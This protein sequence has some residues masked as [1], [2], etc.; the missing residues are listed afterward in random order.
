MLEVLEYLEHHLETHGSYPEITN[1]PP[2]L[3]A[4]IYQNPNAINN[5]LKSANLPTYYSPPSLKQ[6]E[7]PINSRPPVGKYRTQE[8]GTEDQAIRLKQQMAIKLL[9]D[10]NDART[11]KAKLTSIG[12]ST[13]E[14][15]QWLKNPDFAKRLNSAIDK[16][17]TGL[18]QEAKLSLGKLVLAGDLQAI[19]YFHEFTGLFRPE[20]ETVINLT[21]ILAQLMEILMRYVEPEQLTEIAT[22]L[23]E[24]ILNVSSKELN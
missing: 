18:E 14:Y 12:S 19:K 5:L 24:K 4:Q 2:N 20:S 21:K 13:L 3:R 8:L 10:L 11:V 1:V 17:F 23:E 9:L 22:L 15:N 7:E 16:R 6:S